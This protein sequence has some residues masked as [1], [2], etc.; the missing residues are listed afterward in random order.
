MKDVCRAFQRR[1]GGDNLIA[2]TVNRHIVLGWLDNV[3]L[4]SC[5][6]D[7]FIQNTKVTLCS[8]SL[9]GI[10]HLDTLWAVF[11]AVSLDVHLQVDSQLSA[12]EV[13]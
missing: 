2:K 13:S 9:L 8:T 10:S 1:S 11:K 5:R 12:D 6:D 4:S 3:Q 7:I